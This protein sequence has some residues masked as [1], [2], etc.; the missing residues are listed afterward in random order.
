MEILLRPH[1]LY[2]SHVHGFGERMKTRLPDFVN[3]IN[4][5]SAVREG[6]VR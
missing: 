4:L 6:E 3:V 2:H 1:N 5:H